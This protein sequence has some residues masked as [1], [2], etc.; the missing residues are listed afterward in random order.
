MNFLKNILV[1]SLLALSVNSWASGEYSYSPYLGK[2]QDDSG[3]KLSFYDPTSKQVRVQMNECVGSAAYYYDAVL[4]SQVKQALNDAINDNQSYAE[5][6]DDANSDDQDVIMGLQESIN[7]AKNLLTKL[8]K[9]S[10][11]QLQFDCADSGTSYYF[12]DTKHGFYL[13]P[14]SGG[15]LVGVFSR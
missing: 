4:A 2:W 1:F 9:P 6:F 5:S 3:M 11:T 14:V 12:I 8:N 7:T 13:S 10:Y 15:T